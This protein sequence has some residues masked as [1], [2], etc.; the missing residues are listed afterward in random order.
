MEKRIKIE[1]LPNGHIKAET[2]GIRGKDCLPYMAELEKLLSA[3]ITDS[4][5]T[6]DYYENKLDILSKESNTLR[7]G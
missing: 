6:T 3:E 4:N 7:K 1:I 5:Y 2:I